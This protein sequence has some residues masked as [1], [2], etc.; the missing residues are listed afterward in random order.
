MYK[1]RKQEPETHEAG[2]CRVCGKPHWFKCAVD[3]CNKTG[4]ITD[5]INHQCAGTARWVCGEH[6]QRRDA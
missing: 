1:R 3:G 4:T 5:S 2:T 6:W